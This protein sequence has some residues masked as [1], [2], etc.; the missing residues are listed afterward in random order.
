[1]FTRFIAWASIA[2]ASQTALAASPSC[3]D[4]S[5]KLARAVF[6]AER[7]EYEKLES[8]GYVE[9]LKSSKK[10]SSSQVFRVQ[11]S[12]VGVNEGPEAW[13][14]HWVY[15]VKLNGAE[16]AFEQIRFVQVFH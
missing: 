8:G 3:N 13:P 1:M 10:N 14:A 16:C 7:S 15:E 4:V 2:L 12:S 9:Q 11:M 5:L 6:V